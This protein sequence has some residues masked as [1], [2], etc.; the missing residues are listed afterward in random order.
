[1]A[2]KK[3]HKRGPTTK[4]SATFTASLR[5]SSGLFT[6]RR[7][8][9]RGASGNFDR[10][11][12]LQ[13]LCVLNL[14]GLLNLFDRHAVLFRNLSQCL[15]FGDDMRPGTAWFSWRRIFYANRRG[16][17][18]RWTH[19]DGL[20]RRCGTRRL[21][22]RSLFLVGLALLDCFTQFSDFLRELLDL[23]LLRL[24]FY[25]DGLELA[26]DGRGAFSIFVLGN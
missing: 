26:L 10:L 17:R 4:V 21:L 20:G 23:I 24:E 12:N 6:F 3:R 19:R 18:R 7:W 5:T 13:L 2:Q 22:G 14:V 1:M 9:W 15:T 8:R 16:W 25:F 11:T